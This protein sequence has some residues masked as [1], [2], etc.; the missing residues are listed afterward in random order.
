MVI[1]HTL[2]DFL[3][4]ISMKYNE[5]DAYRWYEND[6][7]RCRTYGDL[8]RDSR[9]I[10]S[11]LTGRFGTG[12]HIALLGETSYAWITSYFGVMTGNCVSVPL[13]AKLDAENLAGRMNKADVTVLLLSDRFSHLTDDFRRMCP[14]L[15]AIVS[16]NEMPVLSAAGDP[17]FETEIDENALAQI[18]FTS[19]TTGIG[20]GVMISHRNIMYVT[21]G[22]THLC[23]PGDRLLSVLPLH[24]CF[25]LF[26]TQLSYLLQG[27]VICVNDSLENIMLNMNRFRIHILITVPMLANR[28]AAMIN[29]KEGELSPEQ[30]RGLFGGCFKLIGVGGAVPGE[31]VIKTMQRVGLDVFS[32]YGLTEG[33]GGCIVNPID[34]IRYES[35]G[36]PFVEGLEVKIIDGELCLRGPTVMLGYYRD[37]EATKEAITDGWLH[38]GDLGYMDADGYIYL[39]GRKNN[40]IVTSNGENIY[41]EEL[42]GYM[43]GLPG[44]AEVIVYNRDN[45]LAAGVQL[46]D[47]SYEKAVIEGIMEIN[48]RVPTY[49]AIA[50]ASFQTSPFPVTTSMKVKRKEAIARLLE[51]PP[52]TCSVNE[53]KDDKMDRITDERLQAICGAFAAALGLDEFDQESNFFEEGGDSLAAIEAAAELSELFESISPNDIYINPTP[54]MLYYCFCG[55]SSEESERIKIP[56]INALIAVNREMPRGLGNVLLTGATGYLGVHI[57]H[58]LLE[59]QYAVTC[60][61]RSLEK[62]DRVCGYYFPGYDFS[63]AKTVIGDI[64]EK[65]L[66]LSEAEYAE[67]ARSIDSVIHTA[68]DV[69]HSGFESELQKTNVAGTKEVIA[70]CA[71]AGA[72]LFHT[73]SFAVAGFRTDNRL[74]EDVLDIGQQIAQNV[75]IKSKYQAEEQVLLARKRGIHTCIMRMGYL[76]WR[77]DGMFQINEADNGLVAELRAFKKLGM[78][79]QEL[80]QLSFDFS[81]V[82]ESAEAF[83]LLAENADRDGIWHVINPNR[84]ELAQLNLGKA[85]STDLFV[86]NVARNNAD[87]DVIILSMYMQMVRNGING[88]IDCSKTAQSLCDLG[89]EWGVPTSDIPL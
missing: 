2:S 51:Q 48:R 83:V 12:A 79:P 33:T 56:D 9:R 68:A 50:S 62:F 54:R 13:D 76:T 32:G 44:V 43:A 78:Y 25:E 72:K 58:A 40:M 26:Y 30:I 21:H 14:R 57:L 85:V 31:S 7:L 17:D 49:K 11:Y 5:A 46:K 10:A 35:I 55:E 4:E 64:T 61:I 3:K 74:T 1:G 69:R 16:M 70:F 53:R 87:R 66:A 38:T 59:K 18:M 65:G 80:S 67:L 82:D 42:E 19:G 88:N 41:P 22:S 8:S 71:D 27:A 45:R 84:I 39:N 28:F 23:E 15:Q 29:K 24:H 36:L 6:Q 75:Y 63:A 73:S 77:K 81:G 37:D 20:K 89:F 47:M 52:V 34:S 86:Q 60:L